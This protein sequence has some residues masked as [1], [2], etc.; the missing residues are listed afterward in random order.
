MHIA[1]I[2]AAEPETLGRILYY[3]LLVIMPMAT[4][5]ESRK[6]SKKN[7]VLTKDFAP[8]KIRIVRIRRFRIV[9]CGGILILRRALLG[10]KKNQRQKNTYTSDSC[11]AIL[12]QPTE[13]SGT[14]YTARG[15]LLLPWREGI[16][17]LAADAL[18]GRDDFGL[19]GRS[20]S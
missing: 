4:V 10:V 17:G 5:H 18:W 19:S 1:M 14:H 9:H 3:R 11:C 13:R 8:L 16:D 20:R 15:V 6:L 2:Q 12:V 7:K